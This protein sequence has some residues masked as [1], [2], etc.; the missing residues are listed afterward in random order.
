[1][2]I[3]LSLLVEALLKKKF[4]TK[5]RFERYSEDLFLSFE[6]SKVYLWHLLAY[7]AASNS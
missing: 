5:L 2:P 6:V 4:C 1:V 3:S 7:P